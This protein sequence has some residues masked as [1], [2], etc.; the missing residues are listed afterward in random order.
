MRARGII[1]RK[2]TKDHEGLDSELFPSRDFVSFVV[3][4]FSRTRHTTRNRVAHR[5]IL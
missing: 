1:N 3:D 4:D 2:G 5:R